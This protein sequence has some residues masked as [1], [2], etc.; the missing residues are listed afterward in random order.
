MSDREI[1]QVQLGAEDLEK[2]VQAASVQIK[3]GRGAYPLS[4]EILDIIGY[5]PS[6]SSSSSA[7]PITADRWYA[8]AARGGKE[9]FFSSDLTDEELG[10]AFQGLRTRF[11]SIGTTRT[12]KESEPTPAAAAEQSNGKRAPPLIVLCGEDESYPEHVDKEALL[13]RFEVSVGNEATAV[14]DKDD[15]QELPRRSLSCVLTGADHSITEAQ[16]QQ[17]FIDLVLRYVHSI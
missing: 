7:A 8:Q 3:Q 14:D 12:E 17:Q 13:R 5:G 6:S 16:A 2:S 15:S 11:A 10:D 4:N 1:I 9:D